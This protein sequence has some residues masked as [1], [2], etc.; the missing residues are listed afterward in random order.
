MQVGKQLEQQLVW[1]D[2]PEVCG[3]LSLTI[4][5][6]LN[7]VSASGVMNKVNI[8]II[9]IVGINMV[10]CNFKNLIYSSYA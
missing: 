10:F 1:V 3:L 7:L 4:I 8:Y 6:N 5:D 9:E 2:I